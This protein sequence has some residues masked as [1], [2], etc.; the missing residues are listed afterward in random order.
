MRTMK[1]S[2]L[3]TGLLLFVLAGMLLLCFGAQA[4]EV[5]NRVG[6][7]MPTASLQRWNSDGYSIQSGLQ[8]AGFTVDLRFADNDVDLQINQIDAMID[9]GCGVIIV[10]PIDGDSLDSVLLRAQEEGVA[11]IAYDRLIMNTEAVD[12]YVTF[13]NFA[14]GQ[15]QGNYIK[16]MLQ[17]DSEP[18]PF[19]IEF[20]AGDPAD[21]NG[22][23][24]FNGAMSVLQ[25]YI[26]SG[27]LVVKSGQKSFEAVSTP[28]WRS[29]VAQKRA[30]NILSFYYED[31]STLDA[32]LCS[33]DSTALGV[34]QALEVSN[35]KG[36]WPVITGQDA[37]LPNVRYILVGKQ[38][39]SVFKQP[40]TLVSRVVRMAKQVM[41]GSTVETNTNEYN[42]EKYIPTYSCKPISVTKGNYKELLID[43]GYY[44]A[45]QF[46]DLPS[47]PPEPE[48]G[49]LID[50]QNFTDAVFREYVRRFDSNGN[51]LLSQEEIESVSE[52]NVSKMGIQ[53]L[54]GIEFFTSLRT[55]DCSGNKLTTLDIQGNTALLHLECSDNLLTALNVSQNKELTRLMCTG[56]QLT[57]LDLSANTKLL[58]CWCFGN[59]LTNLNV[60]GATVLEGLTCYGNQLKKLDIR[61][62]PVLAQLVSE[63]Q[64]VDGSMV[65]WVKMDGNTDTAL[66]WL[67]TDSN[68]E[69]VTSEGSDAKIEAYVT[70]CYSVIL[71]R[72]PDP[73]GLET[74]FNEL[75]SGRKAAAEIIDRFVNSEEFLGKNYSNEEAVDIL[76]QTML[77][78]SADAA[79]KANW[80]KKL[81]SGQTLAHVING[82]CFSKEFRDLCDS[83]GI[84]AGFVNIPNTDTTAEG[85]IKAFVQ[86]CYRIIL[87][88]EAD[89]SG[90]QT[91]YEQLSS[92]KKAAAEIIDRFVNSPEF[93]GK[94]YSHSDSVEILYKA[95]LGRGSDAAGKAN[96]VSKLDEG[97]PFSVVINGFCM[98]REFT[99]ICASYGIKPGSVKTPLSGQ[100]E[101]ELSMLAYKAK[102][103][104][105]KKSET[106]P[107]R[108]E[109]INP[110]DT[111]D[112]NIGT[113]VQAV[114]IN[115]G[116]AKEFISRCY[117]C[118]LGREASAAELDN[119]ISQMTNGTKTPDQIARGFLFSNEFK[120]KNVGNE[121]LVKILYKVYMNRDADPEGLATWT[122]KLN[123]GTSLND[124]LNTFS[125]TGEFKKVVSEM[126]K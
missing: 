41:Q 56:N 43:T 10:A 84:K 120:G 8:S 33:N 18:G 108:V 77:G 96:W 121:D 4:S 76:Y 42:G 16:S 103:P 118:I 69:V 110:S 115:E 66:A 70:R 26:D 81:E 13:S 125:K 99:G 51:G 100:S 85:K 25:K 97:R 86:R 74:W 90:M 50:A 80:V 45:D 124:L 107:T 71:G 7:S 5:G 6:V 49:I 40:S 39:M 28:T 105:T 67:Y 2:A 31:G 38:A 88:R 111:I 75:N 59:Q 48:A 102:E 126:S 94:N 30:A 44:T 47:P 63:V 92:G 101:E 78:R 17:L 89:P 14:V 36:K 15:V 93:S 9:N 72:E 119:W 98:S 55:L 60:S 53:L 54:K 35:Y 113:A 58:H 32:W 82:F 87:D 24:F 61:K 3:K 68:V 20:T 91:W 123:N 57:S 64:P 21:N 1:R 83:Y 52:I 117:Q 37:D 23:I 79:G 62:A 73:N 112:L 34:I 27:K 109:I 104:I 19:N 122:E 114:Y 106:N 95:M 29:E 65:S 12:Y 11:I 116:K 22:Q 46:T